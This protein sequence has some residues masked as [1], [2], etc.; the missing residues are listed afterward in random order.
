MKNKTTK[1]GRSVVSEKFQFSSF[2]QSYLTLCDPM[3]Y[4]TLGFPVHH[5]R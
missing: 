4:S 1:E 5:Q 2:S 3:E